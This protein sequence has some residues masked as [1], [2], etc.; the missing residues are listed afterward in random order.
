MASQC[1]EKLLDRIDVLERQ[2]SEKDMIIEEL[3]DQYRKVY[4][5]L[6]GIPPVS[7]NRFEIPRGDRSTLNHLACSDYSK[8]SKAE[9]LLKSLYLL[10]YQ[11]LTLVYNPSTDSFSYE[12]VVYPTSLSPMDQNYVRY[13]QIRDK[14]LSEGHAGKFILMNTDKTQYMFNMAH[15]AI[16]H[17]TFKPDSA[18]ICIGYEAGR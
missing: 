9:N 17:E 13:Y 6:R 8:F 4:C 2:I 12:N 16:D 11:S 15:S 10:P 7:N 1:C 5:E 14:L 18:I 3:K